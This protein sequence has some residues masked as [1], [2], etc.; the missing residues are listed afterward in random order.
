MRTQAANIQT[1]LNPLYQA[2]TAAQTELG[3]TPLPD[4]TNPK[5]SEIQDRR[6]R[7]NEQIGELD[8][9]IG[10]LEKDRNDAYDGATKADANAKKANQTEYNKGTPSQF[11]SPQA[12]APGVGMVPGMGALRSMRGNR[13]GGDTRAGSI[14]KAQQQLWLSHNQGK[15]LDDMQKLYPNARMQ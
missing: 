12:T 8:K 15:T 6:N 2:R 7:L 11:S 14:T 1:Q 13:G 10:G 4:A 3:R 5:A 9:Q